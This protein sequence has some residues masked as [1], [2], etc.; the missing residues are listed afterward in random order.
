MKY[1]K[2]ER[3]KEKMYLKKDNK[4]TSQGSQYYIS[5]RKTSHDC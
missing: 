3:R 4:K 1:I 2:K 5:I